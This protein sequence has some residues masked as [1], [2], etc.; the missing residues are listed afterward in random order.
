MSFWKK[1][2][3]TKLELARDET[4][5]QLKGLDQSQ[6]EYKT[7][8]KTASKLTKLI[9]LERAQEDKVSKDTIVKVAGSVA[10]T[11]VIVGYESRNVITTKAPNLINFLPM[12]KS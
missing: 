8:L 2:E 4:L 5:D 11:L 12:N 10:L 1:R 7:L 6:P 9:D 3:K